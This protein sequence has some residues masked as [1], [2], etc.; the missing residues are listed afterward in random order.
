MMLT[1]CIYIYIYMVGLHMVIKLR[2]YGH[3]SLVPRVISGTHHAC[4]ATRSI[5]QSHCIRWNSQRSEE[6]G[7]S[8]RKEP[9]HAT[10][11][12]IS[13]THLSAWS[14]MGFQM[15]FWTD[16]CFFQSIY[17][18]WTVHGYANQIKSQH[19]DIIPYIQSHMYIDTLYGNTP[20]KCWST[21]SW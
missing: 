7:C 1:D 14:C 2:G 4:H 13:R 12:Q 19:F 10:T 6:L 11:R 8:T 9:P 20:W 3:A 15:V 17:K 5:R 18:Q 21:W 16:A